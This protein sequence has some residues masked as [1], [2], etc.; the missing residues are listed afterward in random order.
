MSRPV[1]V[2]P[3]FY[4]HLHLALSDFDD[5]VEAEVE[6]VGRHLTTVEEAFASQW[7]TLPR[8]AGDTTV[9]WVDGALTTIPALFSVQGRLAGDG[10]IELCNIRIVVDPGS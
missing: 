4:S 6:F 10:V 2:D 9:R 5:S 1:R 3:S 8:S 7:D